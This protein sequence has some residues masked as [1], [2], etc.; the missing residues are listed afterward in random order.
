MSLAEE[1]KT[2]EEDPSSKN[3]AETETTQSD[4]AS[5][6]MALAQS[7]FEQAKY[8]QA[9]STAKKALEVCEKARG[10]DHPQVAEGL[11]LYARILRQKKFNYKAA[12][13]EARAKGILKNNANNTKIEKI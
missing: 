10:H 4:Q 13:L 5:G 9:E 8:I 2:R 6:L 12:Q 7:Y 3:K 1:D 11:I